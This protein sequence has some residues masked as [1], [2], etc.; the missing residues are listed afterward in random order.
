M[1]EYHK[2]NA[3]F[4]RNNDGDKKL[5]IGDWALP[6]FE[7]LQHNDWEFTEKVDG[8]N[9]RIHF[10]QVSGGSMDGGVYFKTPTVGGRTDRAEIPPHLKEALSELFRPRLSSMQHMVEKHGIWDITLYGEGYGPKIQ[11]GGKYREDAS[12]VL[13]DVLVGDIWL[14]RDS[15]NDIAE[16]LDLDSVPVIGYGTLHDAIGI[17]REGYQ[18]KNGSMKNFSN[19]PGFLKSQ[20]GDFEAEGIV[21]R[22]TLPLFDRQGNRII[23]KIKARDFRI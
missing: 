6:E 10:G 2:I 1:R 12:F 7:Y 21:A 11:G 14:T 16:K 9:I 17:V 20:W 19:P 5:V 13:F 22:P 18:I 23:T 15:V 4:K 8:T 3:P